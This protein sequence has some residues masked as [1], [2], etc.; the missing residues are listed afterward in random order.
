MASD[1][2]RTAL[3]RALV[4]LGVAVGLV[5]VVVAFS[6]CATPSTLY[7]GSVEVDPNQLLGPTNATA[8]AYRALSDWA[9]DSEPVL[10][11]AVWRDRSA[12]SMRVVALVDGSAVQVLVEQ[13]PNGWVVPH[14]PRPAELPPSSSWWPLDDPPSAAAT[15]GRWQTATGFL[16]AWLEGGDTSRWVATSYHPPALAAVYPDW[17]I[18]GAGAEFLQVPGSETYV[19]AIEYSA[20]TAGGGGPHTWRVYLAVAQDAAGRW[21]VTGVAHGPPPAQ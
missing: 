6:R 3:R 21:A 16:E 13:T 12:T 5:V 15:D 10:V 14:P 7:S 11:E 17:E 8:A 4:A 19:V 1:G 9:P 20:S 2:K 18:T